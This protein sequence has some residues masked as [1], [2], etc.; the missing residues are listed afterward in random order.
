MRKKLASILLAAALI[1][2]N[3]VPAAE[4]GF[5]DTAGLP[6]AE[7]ISFLAEKGIVTGKAVG[8]YDP[9]AE[10]TRAEM[11]AIVLRAF[12]EE[13]TE[14]LE[15]F[16]DVPPSHWAFLYVER[17]Y[18][19]GI[20][21]GVSETEF[22]PEGKVT[23]E[24]AVKMLVCALGKESEAQAAGGWPQGYMAV[25][26]EAGILE[27]TAGEGNAPISRAAMAQ[28]V[29]N[30]L[31]GSYA[32]FMIDWEGLDPCFDW[33]REERVRGVYGAA[34]DLMCLGVEDTTS[35]VMDKAVAAG[36]N[37]FFLNIIAT[38]P[39]DDTYEGVQQILDET[40]EKMRRYEGAHTFMKINF[41]DGGYTKNDEFGMY[42]P[43]I[44]KDSYTTTP[45]PLSE[46][47]WEK[48]IYSRSELIASYPEF[49]GIVLDCEMYSGGVSSYPSSCMCDDCWEKFW[50]EEKPD[51]DWKNTEITKRSDYN[52][53]A[54]KSDAYTAWME[55]KVEEKFAEARDRILAVN[56][57]CL[58]AYM[59][60]FEWFPGMTRGLGTPTHP[61][62]ILSEAEY[63]G[64]LA[65][66]KITMRKI[67]QEGYPA[68][69]VPGLFPGPGGLNSLELFA[70]RLNQVNTIGAGFWIFNANALDSDQE[71][72]SIMAEANR[73][74]DEKLEKGIVTPLPEYSHFYYTASK[75]AGD[76]PTE[77]EWE[78]AKETETFL[79]YRYAE[80]GKLTNATRAKILYSD[81]ELFVRFICYETDMKN[82]EI[83]PSGERDG[84]VFA[85]DLT[86]VYW[87]YD[88]TTISMHLAA[89]I[90]G[91]LWDAQSSGIGTQNKDYT[92][93]FGVETKCFADRWEQTYR[94]PGSVDGV[95]QIQKG[96]VLRFEL[97]R[98][99][100][101]NAELGET[102]NACWAVTYGGYLASQSLWNYVTLG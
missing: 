95:R 70:E 94:I 56:P 8:I 17:A 81:T 88:D 39:L 85:N 40:V 90:H 20:I 68:L 101:A 2:P 27:G 82:K 77:A 38:G 50:T 4:T 98:A 28:L 72:Y 64:G 45:C 97:A 54:G 6:E 91:T 100:P 15:R 5:T 7:A 66:T 74:L 10:L 93:D 51:G 89:D 44:L 59:P 60:G 75:I 87:K 22:Q 36:A 14:I 42:H 3:G 19:M 25:A 92:Y 69:Y 16:S 86:E 61:C 29:F 63:W 80:D 48:Q 65:D 76:T 24:Q 57:N 73:Y 11:T 84:G 30:S 18:G 47:Y 37:T 21:N 83:F 102:L 58:I 1:M 9:A 12:G 23:R 67:K 49:D 41:G 13:D 46:E 52:K 33:V 55:K 35:E 34:S 43:G 32:D 71:H 31:S 26:E 62:L 79:D 99:R 53:N 96:D 78:K